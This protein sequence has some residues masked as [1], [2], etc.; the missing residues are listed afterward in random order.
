M[1]F[2]SVNTG[3]ERPE[4][5]GTEPIIP[6]ASPGAAEALR[7]PDA[8][9]VPPTPFRPGNGILEDAAGATEIKSGVV[10]D[11]VSAW[12]PPKIDRPADNKPTP[13]QPKP[14]LQGMV[15]GA[16]GSYG[17]GGLPEATKPLKLEAGTDA[18]QAKLAEDTENAETAAEEAAGQTPEPLPVQISLTIYK[19]R[20]RVD[21]VSLTKEPKPPVVASLG[22]AA[23]EGLALELLLEREKAK[24]TKE[25]APAAAVEADT[26]NKEAGKEE[27]AAADEA[28]DKE[29]T[30]ADDTTKPEEA[31]VVEEQKPEESKAEEKAETVGEQPAETEPPVEE[32]VEA[33]ETAAA[34]AHTEEQPAPK[35]QVD[36]SV[37]TRLP[38]KP[39]PDI[40]VETV[41]ATSAE[42]AEQPVELG[43]VTYDATELGGQRLPP[44]H[45]GTSLR[46]IT[47]EAAAKIWEAAATKYTEAV[48]HA[49]NKIF[50]TIELMSH[51]GVLVNLV[52]VDEQASQRK[53]AAS[54]YYMQTCEV[55]PITGKRIPGT[56]R[57]GFRGG[58]F[59]G[60][61]EQPLVNFVRPTS[62]TAGL[63]NEVLQILERQL[64]VAAS[65]RTPGLRG[66]IHL[67]RD[68]YL[69]DRIHYQTNRVNDSYRR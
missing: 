58:I 9:P 24:E 33:P 28:A 57:T 13:P 26:D 63:G 18:P 53:P 64:P 34:P 20:P 61:R 69:L 17:V 10:V 54:A 59:S 27:A 65:G 41:R 45:A 7:Q 47:G 11:P 35:V 19:E 39:Q 36:D 2:E 60:F 49:Q 37:E 14:T 44:E 66:L 42:T 38:P 12:G 55:H 22:D 4:V 40:P 23:L 32:S 67:I 15:L 29:A 62:E 56:G 43:E 5:T 68:A 1:G 3:A 16:D 30:T 21:G 31:A 52:R 46:E 8:A 51:N 25:D 48:T 6:Q 50:K